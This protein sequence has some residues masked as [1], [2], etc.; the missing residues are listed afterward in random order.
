M[1]GPKSKILSIKKTG[2]LEE[3]ENLSVTRMR[4]VENKKERILNR[5]EILKMENQK[6][7]R[8]IE[9]SWIMHLSKKRYKI[10]ILLLLH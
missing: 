4:Q 9:K 7:K 1:A 6:L 8:S 2:K 5:I 3:G 10:F